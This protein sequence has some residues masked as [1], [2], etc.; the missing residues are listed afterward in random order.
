MQRGDVIGLEIDGALEMTFRFGPLPVVV[1][2]DRRQGVM[3][4]AERL[5]EAQRLQR[6]VASQRVRVA[7][8]H[9]AVAAE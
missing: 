3:G 7:D 2:Q 5:V 1:A 9:E 8:R 6:R 4:L